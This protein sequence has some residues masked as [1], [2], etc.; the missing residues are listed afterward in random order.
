M[1]SLGNFEIYGQ[2]F[3]ST[4][5]AMGNLSKAVSDWYLQWY[6]TS[7]LCEFNEI[8]KSSGSGSGSCDAIADKFAKCTYQ[9]RK[10][11][12]HVKQLETENEQLRSKNRG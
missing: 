4:K 6:G 1:F 2:I 11:D 7:I 10:L 9:N 3:V 12:E 5:R 8:P